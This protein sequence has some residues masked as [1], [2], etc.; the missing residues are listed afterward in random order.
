MPS[1]RKVP[2]HHCGP[3]TVKLAKLQPTNSQG[4]PDAK[5]Y[6]TATGQ[7]IFDRDPD[8]VSRTEARQAA[9]TRRITM[10]SYNIVIY[11]GDLHVGG[12]T[13]RPIVDGIGVPLNFTK[14]SC[15]KRRPSIR[16]IQEAR[17]TNNS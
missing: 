6:T 3:V 13:L 17:C 12:F 15:C 5:T 10:R 4:W 7:K 16:Y 8:E 9:E 1:A 2:A 11:E 14:S